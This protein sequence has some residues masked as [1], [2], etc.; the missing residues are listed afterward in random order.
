MLLLL[1]AHAARCAAAALALCA[2]AAWLLALLPAHTHAATVLQEIGVDML[3]RVEPV[4]ESTATLKALTGAGMLGAAV[5]GA[6]PLLFGKPEPA[7]PD[8]NAA[9]PH[10]A[11]LP[12][13]RHKLL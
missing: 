6:A 9:C 8:A 7:L 2:S 4:E 11:S 12:S 13:H 5:V 10:A 1:A 3:P